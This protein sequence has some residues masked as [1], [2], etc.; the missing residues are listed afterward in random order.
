MKHNLS[1]QVNWL[2]HSPVLFLLKSCPATVTYVALYI[3]F[4]IFKSIQ[5]FNKYAVYAVCLTF[6]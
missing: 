3:Y 4:Q 6:W 5:S 1:Q 2:S